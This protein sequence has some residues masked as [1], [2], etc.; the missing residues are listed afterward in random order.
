MR[1]RHL[2]LLGAGLAGPLA[3]ERDPFWPID[4]QPRTNRP[5]PSPV[6]DATQKPTEIVRPR[7]LTDE[8]LRELERQESMRIQQTLKRQGTMISDKGILV[9][10]EG[11]WVGIG[12]TLT[13]E[14]GGNS[15]RL[16]ILKL[17]ADNIELKARRITVEPQP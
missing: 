6:L 3:A 1:L 15:Y 16:E 2:F 8:E 10:L 4:Y 17:T 7:A 12:D 9:N 11:R 13:L 5:S 14:V